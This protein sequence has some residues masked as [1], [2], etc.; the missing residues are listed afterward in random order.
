M[1]E[2]ESPRGQPRASRRSGVRNVLEV[3]QCRE[4]AGPLSW[5][6]RAWWI[7]AGPR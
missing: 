4:A 5:R 2:R 1:L 7:V 3:R 6:T